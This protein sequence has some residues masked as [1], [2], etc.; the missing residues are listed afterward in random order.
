MEGGR[1]FGVWWHHRQPNRGAAPETPLELEV[2]EVAGGGAA[3]EEAEVEQGGEGGASERQ[4]PA[5][6]VGGGGSFVAGQPA[7]H[8]RTL[9][10]EVKG[11]AAYTPSIGADL[12]IVVTA[13]T[14]D[15]S[16]PTLSVTSLLA[17]AVSLKWSK[18]GWDGVK[19]QGRVPGGMTW[20]DLGTDVF[21]PFVDTR[22]LAS[23]NTPEVREYRMCH[24]DGDT[25]LHN[26][27]MSWW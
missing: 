23:A 15:T 21:S 12:D 2:N 6:E 13:P 24:L 14:A 20:A 8:Q 1:I 9:V 27:S 17:G 3:E 18:Q 22:P 19:V 4:A 7:V 26:W 10:G 16:P 11:K 5:G 25:P